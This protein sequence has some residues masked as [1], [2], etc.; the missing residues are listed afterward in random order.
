MEPKGECAPLFLNTAR[1]PG[2]R[3]ETSSDHETLTSGLSAIDDE[4]ILRRASFDLRIGE[5]EAGGMAGVKGR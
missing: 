5:C 1:P 3:V 4:D 2:Y